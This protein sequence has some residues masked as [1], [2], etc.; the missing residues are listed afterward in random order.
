[1]LTLP[2]HHKTIMSTLVID[3]FKI[4]IFWDT[5]MSSRWQFET[6]DTVHSMSNLRSILFLIRKGYPLGAFINFWKDENH[7]CS[8]VR[9]QTA[10]VSVTSARHS[11]PRER[12]WYK[13]QCYHFKF[14]NLIFILSVGCAKPPKPKFLHEWIQFRYLIDKI[15][16][17]MTFT[18]TQKRSQVNSDPNFPMA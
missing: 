18:D 5:L 17:K 6:F 13:W 15:F 8:C 9:A 11:V 7:F 1:M 2:I 16:Q 10:Q 3:S 14:V 12:A 4:L